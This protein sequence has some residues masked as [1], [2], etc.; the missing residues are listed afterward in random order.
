MIPHPET[1]FW[2]SFWRTIWKILEVYVAYLFYFILALYLTFFLAYTLRF[3]LTFYLDLSGISSGILSGNFC[4]IFWHSFWHPIRHLFCPLRSNAHGWGPAVPSEIWDSPGR[5][6]KK[7]CNPP[8]NPTG[9]ARH[10]KKQRAMTHDVDMGLGQK[11]RSYSHTQIDYNFAWGTWCSKPWFFFGGSK[12]W[13]NPLGGVLLG[14]GVWLQVRQG[15]G[16][17]GFHWPDSSVD[18]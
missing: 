15:L 18:S 14:F 9:I 11:Y 17:D 3:Y 4:H 7:T 5:W 16:Q 1:I 13:D 8:W 6:G 10:P 12:F 2:H